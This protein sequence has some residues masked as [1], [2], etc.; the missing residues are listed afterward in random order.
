MM[1]DFYL[2]Y[3]DFLGSFQTPTPSP[4]KIGHHL[5]TLLKVQKTGHTLSIYS[6]CQQ[7]SLTKEVICLSPILGQRRQKFGSNHYFW[8]T[9][10]ERF[11]NK[12]KPFC[13]LLTCN[14]LEK[15]RE[16]VCYYLVVSRYGRPVIFAAQLACYEH[17]TSRLGLLVLK[18]FMKAT[19]WPF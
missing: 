7:S 12:V 16:I 17:A 14:G 3:S 11:L 10:V 8:K 6:I 2:L 19:A 1:S 13:I 18:M 4:P 9:C 5:C 15:W